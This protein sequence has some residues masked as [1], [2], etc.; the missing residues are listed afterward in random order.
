M[1]ER[2]R[3]TVCSTRPQGK[4]F[5]PR[6]TS[7]YHVI[8]Y[9]LHKTQSKQLLCPQTP[10]F[11]LVN[12]G[13]RSVGEVEMSRKLR[14]RCGNKHTPH[15]FLPPLEE[16]CPCAFWKRIGLLELKREVK[17]RTVGR[18]VS[19]RWTTW[20]TAAACHFPS[21]PQVGPVN[22]VRLPRCLQYLPFSPPLLNEMSIYRGHWRAESHLLVLN[23]VWWF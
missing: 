3:H 4:L 11:C 22:G 6:I 9:S 15:C 20:L 17:R 8:G 16:C 2:S 14:S 12:V 13:Q 5:A 10:H 23:E 1:Q 19:V 7:G 21:L 18:G